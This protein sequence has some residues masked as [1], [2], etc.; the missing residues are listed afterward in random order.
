[1]PQ[2]DTTETS[3]GLGGRKRQGKDDG[4]REGATY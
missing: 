3:E 2:G 1:M 4:K